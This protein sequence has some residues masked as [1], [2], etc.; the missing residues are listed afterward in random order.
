MSSHGDARAFAEHLFRGYDTDGDGEIDF[1]E[2][3]CT[4]SISTKGE[5]EEKLAWA[6]QMYDVNGDGSLTMNEAVEII[7]ATQRM[8]GEHSR[9]A[10]E[11]IAQ[12]IFVH[13]DKDRN[14]VLSQE[15][16]IRGAQNTPA[17]MELLQSRPS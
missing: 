16:F 13:M 8:R 7:S 9:E 3:M 12:Q 4:L 15:E 1:Q 11:D 14:A 17:V 2:F 5:P 6:F 10:A